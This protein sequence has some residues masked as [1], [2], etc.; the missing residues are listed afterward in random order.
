MG[1][2]IDNQHFEK[3]SKATR[4]KEA[5]DILENYQNGGEKVKQVK[6]QS[7]RRKYEMM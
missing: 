2:Y 4:S 5:W 1:C 6:L 7:Y 3:I